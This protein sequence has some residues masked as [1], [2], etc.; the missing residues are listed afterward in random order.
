MSVFAVG[1]TPNANSA[2]QRALRELSTA[3]PASACIAPRAKQLASRS[4]EARSQQLRGIFAAF[5]E[6][7]DGLLSETE[8][9]S[10][11]LSLGFDPTPEALQRFARASPGGTRAIDFPSV[12]ALLCCGAHAP[13]AGCGAP[14][15]PLL[16]SSLPH[17]LTPPCSVSQGVR[18]P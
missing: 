8:L 14:P 10:A 7:R 12:S 6:D 18:Q 13:P 4:E 9:I 16:T 5:D 17:P 1:P 3:V 15:T 2:L 11:L